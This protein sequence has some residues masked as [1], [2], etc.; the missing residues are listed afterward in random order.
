MIARY[1]PQYLYYLRTGLTSRFDTVT[2]TVLRKHLVLSYRRKMQQTAYL[3]WSSFSC[4]ENFNWKQKRFPTMASTPPPSSSSY[5]LSNHP[6]DGKSSYGGRDLIGYGSTPPNPKWPNGAKLA[7]NFVL[8]YEEGGE[9]CLLHGDSESEKLLSE[10]VGAGAYGKIRSLPQNM[11]QLL[12]WFI[13]LY[14]LF[15]I[16][17][18]F[19]DYYTSQ[20]TNAMPTWSPSTITALELASGAS[21]AYSHPN[22]FH[23]Q[24]LR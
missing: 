16:E 6:N 5:P 24:S 7:L 23:V 13:D 9:N 18:I 2:A 8:N 22:K 4:S 11:L 15:N 14:W 21:I 10:I 1:I 20:Q 3:L 12:F 17:H 19:I